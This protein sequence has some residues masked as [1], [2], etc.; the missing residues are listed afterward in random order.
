M[1]KPDVERLTTALRKT[2]KWPLVECRRVAE[3]LLRM[4][5]NRASVKRVGD[6][7]GRQ[8]PRWGSQRAM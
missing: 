7:V 3:S 6:V 2:R 1:T 4:Q 5:A 8:A